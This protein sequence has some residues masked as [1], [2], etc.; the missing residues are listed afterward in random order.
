MESLRKA[1]PSEY[2]SILEENADANNIPR[3]GTSSN[4]AYPAGQLNLSE[5]VSH[6]DCRGTF[7][8]F[9]KLLY[10]P[11]FLPE[12]GLQNMGEFGT[13]KGHRD[14]R[15]SE[16][17]LTCMI[18][19][20]RLPSGYESGRFHLLRLGVY[21]KLHPTMVTN[22]CGLNLHGGSPPIAP[23]GVDVSPHAYRMM[24]V[25]YPPSS[26]LSG[27][28]NQVVPLASMPNGRSLNLGP[29]ITTLL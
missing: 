4:V 26:M 20:S 17:G 24:C 5:A 25:A 11:Y 27:P 18:S 28:G 6:S 2:I 19:N 10:C 23:K 22:F 29:E 3:I 13:T 1:A 7:V 16:G 9:S 21:I 12:K 15:D 8:L 14:K